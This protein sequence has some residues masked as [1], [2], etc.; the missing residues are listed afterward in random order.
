MFDLNTVLVEK[1]N[2]A[3]LRAYCIR[4]DFGL[5]QIKAL[6]EI[7]MDALVDFAFGYHKGVLQS[8]YNRRL[9][10]EAAKSIY[11]IK[12][13]ENA[14]KLYLDDNSVLSIDDKDLDKEQRLYEEQIQKKGEFGELLLHVYLRDYFDTIPLLSKIYFKDSDGFTVHGFDAIHIGKELGGSGNDTLFLGESKIYYRAKGNSGQA[15]VK[16]LANDIKDHFFKDFLI[17]EFALVAKKKDS[18]IPINDYADKNTIDNYKNYIQNKD[19]WIEIIQK[20]SDEKGSL[21]KLLSSVTVPLICT[22]E[23]DLFKTYKDINEEGFDEAY[24]LEVQGLRKQ[25][26][27]E[28]KMIAIEKGEPVRTNLN[29]IL[30]L[31][32]IPSKKELVTLLH[33]KVW[34]QHN[35]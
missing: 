32:P 20:V 21:E 2:E 12:G 28:L 35:A 6:A 25:F 9:L 7:L 1:H 15:G 23:S 11:K 16:D 27:D 10:V 19:Q 33:Q 5:C 13:Y 24:E 4:F 18:Y 34:N 30:I 29:I 22:Y 8:Q 26:V 17:R 31:L 3:T 14:K